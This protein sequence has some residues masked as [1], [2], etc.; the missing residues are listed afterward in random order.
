MGL[1]GD[2]RVETGH[3]EVFSLG[4]WCS[5]REI[6]KTERWKRETSTKSI[7][8]LPEFYLFVEIS[9]VSVDIIP[10]SSSMS[11]FAGVSWGKRSHECAL[12]KLKAGWHGPVIWLEHKTLIDHF[13]TH[14]DLPPAPI[15]AHSLKPLQTPIPPAKSKQKNVVLFVGFTRRTV[16]YYPARGRG[17]VFR[18]SLCRSPLRGSPSPWAVSILDKGDNIC[19]TPTRHTRGRNQN[20]LFSAH[21]SCSLFEKIIPGDQSWWNW[22]TK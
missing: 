17:E 19:T 21:S 7:L 6:L 9:R 22:Q 16:Y 13:G 5:K 14:L 4:R 11:N 10:C 20:E 18:W 1:A 2:T 15:A 12:H 3:W 8:F